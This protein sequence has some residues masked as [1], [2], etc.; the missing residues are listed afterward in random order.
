MRLT[1]PIRLTIAAIAVFIIASSSAESD[2]A[3][4]W[5]GNLHAH[6]LWSDGAVY[7]EQAVA[8]YR[9]R[10]YNFLALSDHDILA[11]DEQFRAFD[12]FLDDAAARAGIPQE[13]A[14]SG[15]PEGHDGR[16]W[17]NKTQRA[18]ANQRG[19]DAEILEE[20]RQ[21][22]GESWVETAE[23][24]GDKLVRVKPITDFRHLFEA[25][26]EFMLMDA[27]E[28]SGITPVHMLAVNVGE[29]V[30]PHLP[31]EEPATAA[32]IINANLQYVAEASWTDAHPHLVAV[33]HPNYM[34]AVTAEHLIEA[35][36]L[37]FFEVFNGHRS[38]RN[39]GDDFR[40]DTDRMWDI[41]LAHRLSDASGPLLYGLA[42]DDAHTYHNV[43]EASSSPERGWIMARAEQLTPE[44]I[45][46]AILSGDF[47]ATTGVTLRDIRHE[48]GSLAIAVD[49]APGVNYTIQFIGT[50][51]DAD[52]SS[53][54]VINP[55]DEPMTAPRRYT[56][57]Y[58]A[59]WEFEEDAPY[60][61]TRRY[62]E[63]I[64]EV[65]L[66]V[67]GAE[68]SYEFAG[69]ELY[70]RA[71]IISD[72]THPNPFAEGDVEVAWVQPVLPGGDG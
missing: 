25:P 68:A 30:T 49:A 42:N 66:E 56:A 37:R 51:E 43:T 29:L 53:E 71:K 64:G 32:D 55:D 72:K 11:R 34:G 2:A 62:S 14:R 1:M 41:V 61:V 17:I 40:K 24:N 5:K 23:V 48:D 57:D 69:D 28:I 67:E 45:I 44:A 36:E 6:T 8:Y 38:V 39:H 58:A 16:V 46:R 20:Y 26:G 35:E 31:V 54:P 65:L 3:T 59:N 52:L 70:V 10:G 33:A 19:G 21:R 27:I 9:D 7:P 13:V 12:A 47:Y 18:A 15:F 63:D 4:W 50:R 22:F 60:A